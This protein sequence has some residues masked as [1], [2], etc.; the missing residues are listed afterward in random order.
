[1]GLKTRS[2]SYPSIKA[3]SFEEV[4]NDFKASY[5]AAAIL[6][7]KETFISKIQELFT[8]KQWKPWLFEELINRF[9]CTPETLLSRLT[10]LGPK[11]LNLNKL[12]F[13]KMNHQIGSDHFEMEKELHLNSQMDTHIN[14]TNEHYC[15]RWVSIKAIQNL[16]E[17][18]LRRNVADDLL[19][20]LQISQ[21][22]GSGN[23]YLV[24]SLT[25]PINPN[26]DGL[27]STSIGLLLEDKMGLNIGFLDDPK[28]KVVKTGFSCERCSETNC[29]ER[30]A[31]PIIHEQKSKKI[32]KEEALLNLI[33]NYV[34]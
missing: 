34:K 12:F 27:S 5:L 17:Q 20:E 7:K 21:F 13:L 32:R 14:R 15:R 16:N 8:S 11:H 18:I 28:L 1:L 6:L 29:K 33:E 22:I 4:L 19:V 23:K 3:I 10:T 30:V 24:I 31:Q 2:K 25:E 26:K 9:H